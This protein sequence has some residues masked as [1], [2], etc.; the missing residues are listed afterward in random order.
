MLPYSIQ[1]DTFKRRVL[2]IT[3]IVRIGGDN[4][5]FRARLNLEKGDEL[6]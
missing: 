2:T 4:K 1:L 5:S 3:E 6:Q